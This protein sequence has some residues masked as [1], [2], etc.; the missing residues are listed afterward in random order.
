MDFDFTTETITPDNTGIIT[1]GGVQGLE[2]PAS[3]T[4]N[5]PGTPTLGVLRINTDTPTAAYLEYWNGTGWLASDG[6]VTSVSVVTSNG[7][8]G[9]VATS[10]TT[11]AITL[12]TTVTGVL[13]GNGTAISAATSATSFPGYANSLAGGAAGSVPYQ[14][15]PNSTS[16]STAGT[17]GYVLVSGGS[18]APTW[19]NTP[20][21]TGTNFSG[22][23]NGAL[24]NSSIT[25]GT[26]SIALGATSTTLAGV[27]S[28]TLT[29]AS[30]NV[31]GVGTPVNGSDAV[32]LTYLQ[33][34]VA[35]LEWKDAAAAATTT[36]L[37]AT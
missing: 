1:M 9:T 2:I 5:R 32:N 27:T 15:A 19:T 3:T 37:T 23:P 6:T 17:T 16:F 31:T 21:L 29:G 8:A 7:F 33:S 10:T 30:S 26:T 14:S 20:T 24:T 13:V 34:V 25:I 18:G 4:G 35:G 11:P 12:S 36:N 28:I 22:I